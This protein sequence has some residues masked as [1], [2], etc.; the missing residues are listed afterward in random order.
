[1]D[2]ITRRIFSISS[3][4]DE[5][6]AFKQK[7]AKK[8]AIDPASKKFNGLF[9]NAVLSGQLVNL[10]RRSNR[11][12]VKNTKSVIGNK[13]SSCSLVKPNSLDIC[14]SVVA[15][16]IAGNESMTE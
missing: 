11:K 1:M 8:R 16:R 12:Y 15:C 14:L 10:S 2:S 4:F 3:D 5:F 6:C 9:L 13:S 7:S